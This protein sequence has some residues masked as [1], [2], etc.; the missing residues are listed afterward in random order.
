[1]K[2]KKYFILLKGFF[3][4]TNIHYP[5]IFWA[6]SISCAKKIILIYE[7]LCVLLMMPMQCCFYHQFSF[8]IF[9]FILL[10]IKF[11]NSIQFLLKI[12]DWFINKKF[13]AKKLSFTLIIFINK[14]KTKGVCFDNGTSKMRKLSCLS[15]MLYSFLVF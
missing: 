9:I 15:V 8:R 12:N 6:K 13:C 2:E 11:F 14:D 4:Y 7:L 5:F 10:V 1:M 3:Y